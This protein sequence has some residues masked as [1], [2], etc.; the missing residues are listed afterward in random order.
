[1]MGWDSHNLLTDS[2]IKENKG[3]FDAKDDELAVQIL[4]RRLTETQA[5]FEKL[6]QEEASRLE[7]AEKVKSPEKRMSK[8]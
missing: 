5:C 1:M 7:K 2:E 8:R 3:V 4:K 6:K